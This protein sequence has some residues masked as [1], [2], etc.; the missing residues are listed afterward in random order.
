L[1]PEDEEKI[2]KEILNKKAQLS[3]QNLVLEDIVASGLPVSFETT[4]Q[5]ATSELIPDTGLGEA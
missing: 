5:Q 2:L 4:E 1:P 3:L